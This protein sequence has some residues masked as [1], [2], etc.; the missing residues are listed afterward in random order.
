MSENASE[1]P[2]QF[3]AAAV[4]EGCNLTANQPPPSND[5]QPEKTQERKATATSKDALSG[6][7]CQP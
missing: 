5:S 1:R 3:D 7:Q 4:D 6:R 2:R